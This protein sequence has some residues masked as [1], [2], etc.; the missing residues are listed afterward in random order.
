MA[1]SP[2]LTTIAEEVETQPQYDLMRTL[3]CHQIQ[4]YLTSRSLPEEEILKMRTRS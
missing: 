3:G 1:P 2:G 4:G